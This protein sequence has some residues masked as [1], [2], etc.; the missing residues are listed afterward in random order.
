MGVPKLCQSRLSWLWSPITLRADLGSRCSLKKSCSSCQKLSN[1]MLHVVYTQ[2][3][4]VESQT[5][6][7]TFDL[8]FCHNLCFRS[9]NA[10][11]KP[12]LDIY[13][14]K[15]FQWYKKHYNP[16]S[17]DPWNRSLKFWKFTKT[18]FPK[19]GVALGVWGFIPSQFPTLP[20]ACDVTSGLLLGPQPCNPFYLG[21]KPKARV[22]TRV[23]LG[24]GKWN[25]ATKNYFLS[26]P[27]SVNTLAQITDDNYRGGGEEDYIQ[28]SRMDINLLATY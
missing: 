20:R 21:C 2:V 28:C 23:L 26:N 9:P 27:R 15:D 1:S 22:A 6:N 11:C 13:V 4:Q 17:F 16:L 10:Q 12:I 8:S 5:S 3:N 14:L 19:V 18:P 7:L 25:F 24:K